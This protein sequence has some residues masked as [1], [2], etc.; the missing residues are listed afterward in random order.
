M[1]KFMNKYNVVRTIY[2]IYLQHFGNFFYFFLNEIAV[3]YYVVVRKC[4]YYSNE[5]KTI[6]FIVLIN[7]IFLQRELY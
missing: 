3:I 2:Y 7:E 1:L 6:F 4:I 5:F